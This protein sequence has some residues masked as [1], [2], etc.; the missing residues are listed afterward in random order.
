MHSD[1]RGSAE[2]EKRQMSSTGPDCVP[3]H[4][5]D[6][7]PPFQEQ[8]EEKPPSR[9]SGQDQPPCVP[10]TPA[11]QTVSPPSLS[12]KKGGL[13]VGARAEP[14]VGPVSE[15]PASALGQA[16][17]PYSKTLAKVNPYAWLS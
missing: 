9:S 15:F 17:G 12:P 4:P 3:A 16:A 2:A 13:H 11:R 1:L 14:G 7:T 5:S 10:H 8:K 6:L